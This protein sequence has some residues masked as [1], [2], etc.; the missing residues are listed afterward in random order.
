MVN[1]LQN[2]GDGATIGYI[3]F[4]YKRQKEQTIH[5][6]L[7]CLLRQL[8]E[9]SSEASVDVESLY[10]RHAQHRSPH[11]REEV[12]EALRNGIA[13]CREAFIVVDALDEYLEDFSDQAIRELLTVLLTLGSNIKLMVTS[14]VLG[15]ME[16]IFADLQTERLEI[17]ATDEDLER[18]VKTRIESEPSFAKRLMG[19]LPDKIVQKIKEIAQG[20]YVVSRSEVVWLLDSFIVF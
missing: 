5:I 16:G 11:K 1:Y 4:N 6:L 10:N 12:E 19:D 3:Y 9:T 17:R 13:S 7:A 18:Y 14:R 20:R 2:Q 8:Y 15:G